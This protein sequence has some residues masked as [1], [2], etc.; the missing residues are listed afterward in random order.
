M[1]KAEHFYVLFLSFILAMAA[2][3]QNNSG[4]KERLKVFIDC[5][6]T[7]CDMDF[8]RTEINIVDFLADRLASDVHVLIT[9]QNTGSGNNQY[10][11]IFYG[12]NHSILWSSSYAKM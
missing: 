6:N 8:I 12:Q 10:Q 1:F 4:Q 3:A 7:W 9:S 2:S 11:M 5:S